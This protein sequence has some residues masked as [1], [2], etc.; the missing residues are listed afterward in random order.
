VSKTAATAPDPAPLRWNSPLSDLPRLTAARRNAFGQAGLETV[1]DLLRH[2]PRRH[3]DRRK[4]PAFPAAPSPDP[5][6]LR[7]TVQSVRSTYFG[8]RSQFTLV[9]AEKSGRVPAATVQCRWFNLR[10]L[11]K[12]LQAGQDLVIHG[13]ARA[14]KK[15][16]LVFDHPDFEI[17]ET[18]AP[19]SE[20]IHLN[21]IAPVHPSIGPWSPRLL[22]R[23]IFE[24]LAQLPDED[25][26]QL[27][28]ASPAGSGGAATH[29]PPPATSP[30]P[31]PSAPSTSRHH[32]RN[33]NPPAPSS[34][35]KNSSK[36][37]ASSPGSARG[38]PPVGHPLSPGKT[39]CS[40]GFSKLSP[41]I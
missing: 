20:L 11:P 30:P 5:L 34:P 41:S 27:W 31:A 16:G 38:K 3:E 4:F 29:R 9:L 6:C 28:P 24:T 33:S 10:Y 36:C 7:G 18:D 37:N 1:H 35:A 21:R 26:P 25:I 13:R 8:R 40:R 23:L 32:G 15:G 12:I 22:R 19:D 17:L 39:R 2:Y 14:L